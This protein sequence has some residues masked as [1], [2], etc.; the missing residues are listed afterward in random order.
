MSIEHSLTPIFFL[1]FVVL[2]SG[3]GGTP[4]NSYQAPQVVKES[5]DTLK[6]NKQPIDFSTAM[7]EFKSADPYT[8]VKPYM[9]LVGDV[10]E[11]NSSQYCSIQYNQQVDRL[12]EL[13]PSSIWAYAARAYCA[14][15]SGQL[16]K[17]QR[18]R[19]NIAEIATILLSDRSGAS[20]SEAFPIRELSE[21]GLIIE[22]AG[23]ELLEAESIHVDRNL[24]FKLHCYDPEEDIFTYRY[25]QN[26]EFFGP[27]L[28]KTLNLEDMDNTEA[29]SI[30][31]RLY[32]E[33]DLDEIH[34]ER[35]RSALLRFDYTEVESSS[36]SRKQLSP[37]ADVLL[38]QSYLNL[39]QDKKLEPML[40]KVIAHAESGVI[41][42]KAFIIVFMFLKG[43]ENNNLS[44]MREILVQ[45]NKMTRSPNSGIVAIMQLLSSRDD[46]AKQLKRFL[47]LFPEPEAFDG[48]Y[49]YYAQ[50]KSMQRGRRF[51]NR[52]IQDTLLMLRH[53]GY[54]KALAEYKQAAKAVIAK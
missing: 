47:T 9:S 11:T 7:N 24:Y 54:D 46:Y 15:Q 19:D 21:A 20:P 44:E 32:T 3:C 23:L 2:V 51:F 42:A 13:N 35:M 5:T 40:D 27:V 50:M 6:N 26:Y 28:E 17:A 22:S 8:V 4:S 39:G 12:L 53:L 37:I 38:A 45:I 14:E 18:Y 36:M 34:I 43:E 30:M 49:D 33:Q 16:T 29:S 41:E 52:A 10:L 48:V 1:S 31:T 25:A